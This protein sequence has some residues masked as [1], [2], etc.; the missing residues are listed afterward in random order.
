MT[1]PDLDGGPASTAGYGAQGWGKATN[2]LLHAQLAAPLSSPL[3]AWCLA[4]L[5]S[6]ARNTP[7]N[8]L[9]HRPSH[10]AEAFPADTA[11][12]VEHV[13]AHP[14]ADMPHEE[15]VCVRDLDLPTRQ[16]H[17]AEWARRAHENAALG[18]GNRPV[19]RITMEEFL[20]VQDMHFPSGGRAPRTTL[21][22]SAVRR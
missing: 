6:P 11:A 22:T 16:L 15:L 13:V 20:R 17:Y 14:L 19:S 4:Q 12:A 21:A 10:Q 2:L 1:R 7:P 9:R 8:P 3:H 18:R 5:T